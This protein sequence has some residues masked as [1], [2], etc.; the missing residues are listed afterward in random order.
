MK[1][2]F[3]LIACLCLCHAVSGQNQAVSIYNN[4]STLMGTGV[5][6]NGRMDGLWKFADPKTGRLIQQGMFQKGERE[7]MWTV[8]HPNN[9]K[10]LE[11]EYKAGR[12]NGAFREFGTTGALILESVYKDSL[13]V[14]PYK[15]Y[16]GSAGRPDFVNPKQVMIEGRYADGKKHGEW[17][18]Y[19]ENGQLGVKQTFNQDRLEGPYLEY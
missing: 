6:T 7:G 4:D 14:G 18:S 13:L 17:L 12:L 9:S 11:A 19:F 5:M 1:F 16:Y 8:Y 10:K 2:S 3:V 15:Q